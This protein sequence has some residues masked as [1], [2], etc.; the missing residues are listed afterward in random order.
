MDP[1]VVSRATVHDAGTSTDVTTVP[2]WLEP[3]PKDYKYPW[4]N[5]GR[6]PSTKDAEVRARPR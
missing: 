1:I 2:M 5:L 4:K 6:L 3:A